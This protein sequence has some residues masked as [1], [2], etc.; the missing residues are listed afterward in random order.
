MLWKVPYMWE[1]GECWIIGGG[2]SM[3]RQFGVPEELINSVMEGRAPLRA[4]SPYLSP[5]HDKHVIGINMAFKLGD[6]IDIIFF[7]DSGF[8]LKNQH[9]LAA[10]NG[11]KVSCHHEVN[12]LKYQ[13]DNIKYLPKTR[14]KNHGISDNPGFVTWNGNSGAAAISI[15]ANAGAKRI[16]LLG[17][18]M[19]LT[20]ERSHWH[21]EYVSPDSKDGRR[22]NQH[23]PFHKHLP[24]FPT[25]AADAEK[26]GIEILNASPDSAIPHFKKVE[27]KD[28]L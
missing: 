5:I 9:A 7:G 2:P 25:I 21:R 15:A 18:D 28:L 22:T 20:D 1:G 11:I 23:L 8:F 19:K 27:V 24:G 12:S 6:W 13:T 4:F 16:I 3:P 17:F 10:Y 26:R 14:N